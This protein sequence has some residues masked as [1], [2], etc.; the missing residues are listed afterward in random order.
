MLALAAV[1][2][3]ASTVLAGLPSG[4]ARHGRAA[5]GGAPAPL[6]APASGGY[7]PTA[8]AS[9]MPSGRGRSSAGAPGGAQSPTS[10]LAAGGALPS[11]ASW[12]SG[13]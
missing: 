12:T 6:A 1:L 8:P 10:G 9:P 5:G 11:A 7:L 13:T 3:V 4:G 2:A